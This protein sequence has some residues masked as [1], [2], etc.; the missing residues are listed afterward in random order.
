MTSTQNG[1]I[2]WLL[3]NGHGINIPGK[4]SPRLMDGRQFNEYEFNREIVSIM[5]DLLDRKELRSLQLV[6]E[7]QYVTITARVKRANACRGLQPCVLVSVHSNSYGN[8]KR[9]PVP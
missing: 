5:L 2:L 7:E 8:F 1:K 3:D 9:F 4:R 6:P